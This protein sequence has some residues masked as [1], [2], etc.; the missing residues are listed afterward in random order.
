MD[1]ISS[2]CRRFGGGVGG[3]RAEAW[4]PPP[5]LPWPRGSRC[6][7]AR[8]AAECP[9]RSTGG[10]GVL[11]PREPWPFL[12]SFPR[13]A[14]A[15]LRQTRARAARAARAVCPALPCGPPRLFLFDFFH[16]CGPSAL[17][18]RRR[19]CAAWAAYVLSPHAQFSSAC[20]NSIIAL[21]AL[22]GTPVFPAGAAVGTRSWP[23][24]VALTHACMQRQ[25]LVGIPVAT[26]VGCS[27]RCGSCGSGM[28]P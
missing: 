2:I 13:S 15:T 9:G 1:G 28:H 20:K 12:L 19:G 5:P 23:A 3:C 27:L 7:A 26:C 17:V 25:V 22:S 8:S 14:C 16:G 6:D 11:N 4:S 10:D 18:R 24:P 21:Y